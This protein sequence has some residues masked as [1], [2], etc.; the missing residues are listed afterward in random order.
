MKLQEVTSNEEFEVKV[1]LGQNG[2]RNYTID[3]HTKV[4]DVIGD[5]DLNFRHGGTTKHTR[6]PVQFGTIYGSFTVKSSTG[7]FE[8]IIGCPQHVTKN[9]VCDVGWRCRSAVGGPISVGGYAQYDSSGWESFEGFPQMI[10]SYLTVNVTSLVSMS[11][12]H[13]HIRAI[14]TRLYLSGCNGELEGGMMGLFLIKGLKQVIVSRDDG[15]PDST[16]TETLEAIGIINNHLSGDRI[17]T[18]CQIELQDAGLAK[19]AKM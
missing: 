11:G 15:E 18:E 14:N 6:I 2:I 7:L 16:D 3:P 4:I 17:L 8:S 10:G 19:Y 13:K 9:F 5:V 1:W 12:I